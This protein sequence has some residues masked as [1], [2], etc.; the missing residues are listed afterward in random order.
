MSIRWIRNV[1]VDGEETTLEI[2]LGFRHM[3][4]RCYVRVGTELEEYFRPPSENREDIVNEGL[5]KLQEKLKDSV[6]TNPDGS[7]YEWT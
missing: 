4:D 5:L 1:V 3:G 6:V 2:Q 7:Y